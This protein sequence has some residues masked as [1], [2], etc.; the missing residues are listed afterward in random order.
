MTWHFLSLQSER[1]SGG[2][3][4]F[5]GLETV[6]IFALAFQHRISVH[7]ISSIIS[8]IEVEMDDGERIFTNG[9]LCREE[10]SQ[11]QNEFSSFSQDLTIVSRVSSMGKFP[12]TNKHEGNRARGKTTVSRYDR[13]MFFQVGE[14]L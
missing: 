3:L 10:S 14:K 11:V 6:D 9:T 1:G 12:Y 4:V 13:C 8:L 5:R 7:L 2:P